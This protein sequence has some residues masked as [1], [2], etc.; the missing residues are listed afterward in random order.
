MARMRALETRYPG[1]DA[2]QNYACCQGFFDDACCGK[3]GGCLA[4]FRGCPL[5]GLCLEALCCHGC[6]V[7]STR[8]FVMMEWQLDVDP[9]DNQIIRFSNCM[10]CLAVIC[11]L[12]AMF[13]ESFRDAAELIECIA[14]IVYY[15]TTGCMHAQVMAELKHQGPWGG[16][17]HGICR[18]PHRQHDIADASAPARP[19][20]RPR[21]HGHRDA[22]VGCAGR[23]GN[24]NAPHRARDSR[25]DPP[26]TSSGDRD[27]AI[28]HAADSRR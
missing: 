27:G 7:S 4:P 2:M 10:Q 16:H 9:M 20:G 22:R 6:A 17:G 28:E 3:V 8:M 21:G 26:A 24:C 23:N 15:A 25:D 1:H 19:T 13:D 11:R 14:D 18:R 5:V 12:A